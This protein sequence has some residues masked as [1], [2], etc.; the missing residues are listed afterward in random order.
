MFNIDISHIQNW[1]PYKKL[2]IKLKMKIV[3][4]LPSATEIVSSIGLKDKLVG[5]S[6]ECDYPKDISHLPKLTSSRV[7]NNLNSKEINESINILLK[8]SLSIYQ[9]D[10]EVLKILNPDFILTQS[11]CDI[12]AV[13]IEQVKSC[14]ENV[15]L[16]NTKIIDLQAT[17]LKEILDDIRKCGKIFS[18]TSEANTI[19]DK[20]D[21]KTKQVKKKIKNKHKKKVL[22]I[23]WIQP[24]MLAGN[25]MPDLIHNVNSISVATTS[26]K[27]SEFV[28]NEFLRNLEFDVVIF[29]PCGYDIK[30]TFSELNK[31]QQ[32]KELLSNKKKFIVNGNRYFN[33]PGT[34]IFESIDILCEILHPEIF[35]P[36]PSFDRWI[37]YDL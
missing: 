11:Q 29:S 19:V 25:W 4:L 17:N 8:N 18:K 7:H 20:F 5:V 16:K 34:S 15:L 21:F 27:H 24:I 14:L 33:R 30:K 3:S 36:Q 6:H 37:K 13:S 1:L 10:I 35:T 28:S 31:S 32:L 2:I 9:V 12:C 23:E 26:G 22:C